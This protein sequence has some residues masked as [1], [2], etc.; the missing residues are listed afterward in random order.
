MIQSRAMAALIIMVSLFSLNIP[1]GNAQDICSNFNSDLDF[2]LLS[3]SAD[4][5][6][7][8]NERKILISLQKDADRARNN[9]IRAINKDFSREL[10]QINKKFLKLKVGKKKSGAELEKSILISNAII[11]RDARVGSLPSV[12]AIT[13]KS[14]KNG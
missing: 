7:D 8:Q 3:Y 4:G 6:F 12:S 10:N 5:R 1:A 13:T 11:R 9:C 14:R 2:A